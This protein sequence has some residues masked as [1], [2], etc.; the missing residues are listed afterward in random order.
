[1]KEA[2]IRIAF[3]IY[4]LANVAFQFHFLGSFAEYEGLDRGLAAFISA[5]LLVQNAFLMFRYRSILFPK[6]PQ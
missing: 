4:S 6:N 1:M 5:L 3:I 2:T